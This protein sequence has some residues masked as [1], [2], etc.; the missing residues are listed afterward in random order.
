MVYLLVVFTLSTSGVTVVENYHDFWENTLNIIHS[1]RLIFDA[2]SWVLTLHNVSFKFQ[3]SAQFLQK[4]LPIRIS[5]RVVDFQ[6]LPYIAVCN[7][8]IHDVVSELST[9]L[10]YLTCIVNWQRVKVQGIEEKQ[11]LRQPRGLGEGRGVLLRCKWGHQLKPKISLRLEV[12][13][14]K[15]PWT[16]IKHTKI[17][18]WSLN[19]KNTQKGL[20]LNMFV[21]VYSPHYLQ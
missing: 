11:G 12:K 5:R 19:L 10:S 3:K 13:L 18:C 16:K 8:V 6:K 15:I 14:S 20:K 7:P 21:F 2:S 17:P 9:L 4:E 1:K